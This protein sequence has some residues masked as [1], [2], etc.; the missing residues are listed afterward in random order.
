[1]DAVTGPERVEFEG[2]LRDCE[3]CERETR[4]L[5][6]TATRL[7]LAV[8]RAGT[9]ALRERVLDR[10][11]TVRQEPPE[12]AEHTGGTGWVRGRLLPPYRRGRSGMRSRLSL[13]L[14]AS[15]VAAAALGGVAVWQHQQMQDVRSEAGRT[16]DQVNDMSRVM[17]AS[18]AV[19]RS[20]ALT[21]GGR[22]MVV[23]SHSENR[24]VFFAAG[25]PPLA[26]G[27]VYQLW[28]ADGGTMRSA[29]LMSASARS[30]LL[31]GKVGSASGVGVTVEPAGGS[32]RPTSGPLAVLAFPA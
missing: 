10:I 18:D 31:G 27:K 28:F 5:S 11:A 24:A 2:H 22:A 1:M 6:E 29:G 16:R 20:A 23:M 15:V 17:A 30:M 8:G 26:D 7:G 14:A 21:G 25:L 12:V 9:P 3:A 19:S 13:A 4:E 32:A